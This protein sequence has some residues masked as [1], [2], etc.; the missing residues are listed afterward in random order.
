MGARLPLACVSE[1]DVPTGAAIVAAI[2]LK[3]LRFEEFRADD[4]KVASCSSD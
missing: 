1:S 4:S 2:S 3:L